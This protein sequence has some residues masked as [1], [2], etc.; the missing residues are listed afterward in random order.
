MS[1]V[2]EEPNWTEQELKDWIEEQRKEAYGWDNI[3]YCDEWLRDTG[4]T[5]FRI[6]D[7]SQLTDKHKELLWIY[8][9]KHGGA[10][11]FRRKKAEEW[12]R[13]VAA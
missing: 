13:K 8:Y 2:V 5:P 9:I 12:R 4:R 10:K 11:E 7:L 3:H 6:S 1:A